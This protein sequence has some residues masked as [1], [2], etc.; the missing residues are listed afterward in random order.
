MT[1]KYQLNCSADHDLIV[2][3][4]HHDFSVEKE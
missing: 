2:I 1:V 3:N 4:V